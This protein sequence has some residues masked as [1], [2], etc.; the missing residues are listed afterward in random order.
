M[1]RPKE[2][3]EDQALTAAMELFW[4]QGY[5]AAS[6]SDLTACM[7]ISRQSLYNTYGD[8]H[9]LFL[10]ALD[11]YCT[12]IGERLLRPLARQDAGLAEIEQ[13]I[14]AFIDFLVAYPTPR[15]CLMAN[16]AMEIAPHDQTVAKKV[17]T[18]HRTLEQAFARALATA[19]HRGEISGRPDAGLLARFLVTAANGLAIAAKTGASKDELYAIADIALRNL[20]SAPTAS[21]SEG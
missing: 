13:T 21:T 15:A 12:L 7:G 5:T 1:P 10:R 17:Q 16:S 2:F 3:D 19:Q 14:I 4:Q 11:R 18:F 9:A 20:R 8:K 6:L